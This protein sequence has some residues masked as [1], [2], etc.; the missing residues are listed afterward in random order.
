MTNE[1]IS[2]II[3]VYNAEKTLRRCLDSI[4]RQT[5]RNLE[6]LLLND[7]SADHSLDICREYAGRDARFRV[8][9]LPHGGVAK[10]RNYALEHM[11][12]TY[13]MFA[14]ADDLVCE[15]YVERLYDLAVEWDAPLVSCNAHDTFDTEI[16]TYAYKG[17]C[18]AVKKTV[19][20]LDY[21]QR[22]SLR[23][24]WGAVFRRADFADIRFREEYK[25][26]TDTLFAA[27]CMKRSGYI[28]HTDDELYCYILYPQ[29]VSH[30]SVNMNRLDQVRVWERVSEVF[31]DPKS[32]P[33][34]TAV[35][36]TVTY[37][38][39]LLERYMLQ[40]E[41]DP[42][43]YRELL[44]RIRGKGKLILRGGRTWADMLRYRLYTAA[45]VLI[46]IRH[47]GERK[48]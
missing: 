31:D 10:A 33:H 4:Q 32:L 36:N 11:N 30:G 35:S 24:V 12:G 46:R 27:E 17:K 25:A 7:A 29:S 37:S 19:E 18:K 3:P 40:Q 2:V 6:I 20:E 22:W 5:Y 48:Q 1:M 45:P 43:V 41:K 28:I 21:M 13:F 8:F 34:R 42:A 38:V 26:A 15:Q 39:N 44:K 9:D 16:K 23:V 14:D 47:I